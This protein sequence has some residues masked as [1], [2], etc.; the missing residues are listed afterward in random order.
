MHRISRKLNKLKNV[1]SITLEE[2]AQH[3]TGGKSILF[4]KMLSI[5][6]R[7]KFSEHYT[8]GN[9]L[10]FTLINAFLLNWI[11]F[12]SALHSGKCALHCTG[13]C[14]QHRTFWIIFR[15]I[16]VTCSR[17]YTAERSLCFTLVKCV[18]HL[19]SSFRNSAVLQHIVKKFP[20]TAYCISLKVHM[21]EI[22]IVC[23]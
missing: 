21:H 7:W 17:L 3:Y 18:Q 20:A 2:R 9:V 16:V 5:L 4:K 6:L 22:F 19:C 11:I 13:E 12:F 14:F 8:V 1:L 23:F 10:C 15:I